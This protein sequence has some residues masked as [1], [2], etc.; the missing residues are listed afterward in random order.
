MKKNAEKEYSTA[1]IME[2]ARSCAPSFGQNIKLQMDRSE[3]AS[4][5]SAPWFT[6]H[7]VTIWTTV[8]RQEIVL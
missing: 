8:T 2:R 4:A 6:D 5:I 3:A 1:G 7:M